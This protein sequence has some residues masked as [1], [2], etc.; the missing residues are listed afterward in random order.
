[1]AYQ[2]LDDAG[3]IVA[4]WEHVSILRKT[5]QWRVSLTIADDEMAA[6]ANREAQP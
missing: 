5:D 3:E 2:M 1:M 6:W 4:S